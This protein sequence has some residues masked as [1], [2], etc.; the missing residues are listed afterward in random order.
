[1]ILRI[2]LAVLLPV[3]HLPVLGRRDLPEVQTHQDPLGVG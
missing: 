2:R 1:M 3:A